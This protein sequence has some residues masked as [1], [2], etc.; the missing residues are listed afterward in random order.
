MLRHALRTL[1]ALGLFACSVAAHAQAISYVVLKGKTFYVEL[2]ENDE[3]HMRGLMFREQMA[4][5]R[6]MLFI[7][8]DEY[9]QA[10]WMKNTLIP[11][12]MLYFDKNFHVVSVQNNVPPCKADPCPSYP[13]SG[14]AKYVLELNGGT[15]D[16]LG[17]K[18]GDTLEFHR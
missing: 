6:G 13:S 14:P 1:A 17:V 12:D 4:P 15:A 2:A 16:K 5:D 9:M 7:F 11:L 10:F 18:P 3:Q 8:R